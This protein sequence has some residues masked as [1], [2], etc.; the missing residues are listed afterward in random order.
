MCNFNSFKTFVIAFNSES[1]LKHKHG[2]LNFII[3]PMNHI[4]LL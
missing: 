3:L 2:K 4:V 1:G